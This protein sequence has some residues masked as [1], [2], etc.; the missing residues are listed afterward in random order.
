MIVAESIAF[1]SLGH[2]DLE[3]C[4]PLPKGQPDAWFA[5]LETRPPRTVVDLGCGTG[6]FVR[7]WSACNRG[8]TIGIDHSPRCIEVA[9]ARSGGVGHWLCEDAASWA[10]NHRNSADLTVCIGVEDLGGDWRSML[11]LVD[12]T[13]RRGKWALVGVTVRDQNQAWDFL[14]DLTRLIPTENELM[15]DI[16]HFGWRPVVEDTADARAW[17]SFDRVWRQSIATWLRSHPEHPN[18]AQFTERLHHGRELF[19]A[20]GPHALRFKTV[21]AR[22]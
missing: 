2:T 4:A 5:A 21:L 7:T 3:W 6:A 22:V 1:E 10:I 18:A 11:S 15:R 14:P 19:D 9:R 13:T 16:R 17:Q 20:L 12:H 8:W